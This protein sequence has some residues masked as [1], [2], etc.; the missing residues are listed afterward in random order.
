MGRSS[1]G[2]LGDRAEQTALRFLRRQGLKP[3]ARNFRNRGGEIDLIMQHADCL[4]FVE[5]RFRGS[6]RFLR[7]ALSV[8]HHKQ[9][10][11]LRTAAMFLAGSHQYADLSVRFDVV[12][13]VGQQDVTIEWIRDA[14]RPDNSTL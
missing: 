8:D 2:T 3:V 4:V 13:V 10:K 9:R 6:T 11:I 1:A 14:F 7:P 12:A 5:V